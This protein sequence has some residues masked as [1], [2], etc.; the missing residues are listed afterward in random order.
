VWKLLI[1]M[2]EFL[3]Y[4]PPRVFCWKS[5]D[6]LDCKGVGVLDV[7]KEFATVSAARS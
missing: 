4:T 1:L 3:R 2:V 5:V 6:L 7:A